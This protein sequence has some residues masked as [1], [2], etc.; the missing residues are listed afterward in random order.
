MK[1]FFLV[2]LL[3]PLFGIAQQ[4]PYFENEVTSITQKYDTIWDSS[5]ETIVFT[6]SSS[7]RMWKNISDYFPNH[8]LLNTGFG[9]SQTIDL[10]GYSN[11]L[12]LNYKPKK[13][14]IYEGDNDISAKKKSKE[15]MNTFKELIEQIKQADSKTKIVI[16]S[17]KPS[18]ARW[19]LKGK[20]KRLNRKL[21]KICTTDDNLEYANVWDVMLDKRKL[22]TNLFLSDGLHMNEIG[23]KLWHG[24]LKNYID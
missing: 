11:E 13:V 19:N 5:R 3:T 14:F 16:I 7:I 24:V 9:G 17:A 22:K 2:L 10:L 23:Y 21:K 8:Q 12:I 4:N 6:G 1:S 18:I 15:I 20:Y